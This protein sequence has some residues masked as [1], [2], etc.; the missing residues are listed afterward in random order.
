M[1]ESKELQK[2]FEDIDKAGKEAREKLLN[3]ASINDVLID[4]ITIM[5]KPV[6]G[7]PGDK[8]WMVSYKANKTLSIVTCEDGELKPSWSSSDKNGIETP[9]VIEAIKELAKTTKPYDGYDQSKMEEELKKVNEGVNASLASIVDSVVKITKDELR[10]SLRSQ[11]DNKELYDLQLDIDRKKE[12]ISKFTCVAAV[13]CCIAIALS[14]GLGVGLGFSASIPKL[15]V[16]G[17][18]LNVIIVGA[19]K[20]ANEFIKRDYNKQLKVT[21]DHQRKFKENIQKE[22]DNIIPAR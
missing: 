13:L 8:T 1:D 15:L 22:I 14:V 4:A 16:S 9:N 17:V 10:M 3:S 2:L 5:F 12:K 11:M 19:S 21:E 7:E 6:L 18:A 20:V